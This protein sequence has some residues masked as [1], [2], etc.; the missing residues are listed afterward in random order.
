[1]SFPSF[2]L[3]PA[4]RVPAALAPSDSDPLEAAASSRQ[5]F[6]PSS[7]SSSLRPPR[8]DGSG[9]AGS[10]GGGYNNPDNDYEPQADGSM[11]S[12]PP[13]GAPQSAVISIGTDQS[14]TPQSVIVFHAW[15]LKPL[16][17]L[18][19]RR[20]IGVGLRD[21]ELLAP[22]STDLNVYQTLDREWVY[23]I[24][25]PKMMHFVQTASNMSGLVVFS[26]VNGLP[27]DTRL[28]FA[29]LCSNASEPNFT[30]GYGVVQRGGMCTG[31]NQGPE[32]IRALSVVYF[33]EYPYTY[34]DAENGQMKSRVPVIG[35]PSG[36]QIPGVSTSVNEGTKF[37]P[38][39]FALTETDVYTLIE[40]TKRKCRTFYK[41]PKT[42]RPDIKDFLNT[43]FEKLYSADFPLVHYARIYILTQACRVRA[44][45]GE[46]GET[47][48]EIATKLLNV[49]RQ[50]YRTQNNVVTQYDAALGYTPGF[51]ATGIGFAFISES[52]KQKWEQLITRDV[53]NTLK[54]LESYA[55]DALGVINSNMYHFLLTHIMGTAMSTAVTG[56]KIDLLLGTP[57]I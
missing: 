35:V 41:N 20:A 21:H 36:D 43:N 39:Q 40:N 1:M 55:H 31:V 42:Q 12:Y 19:Y 49:L 7:S 14:T 33:S 10:G 47:K 5:S 2:S 13:V 30:D 45:H 52:E 38:A 6:A 16:D 15:Y 8:R 11:H 56:E 37:V 48:E 57:I 18:Q 24:V 17:Q 53:D 3:Q 22:N 44:T 26:M 50:F 23:S 25:K 27:K 32:T 34:R 28:Q 46:D 29:G 4:A 9:G 51:G 54:Q